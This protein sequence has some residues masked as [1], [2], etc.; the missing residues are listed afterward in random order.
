MSRF[1]SDDVITTD[2]VMPIENIF[3][4]K[5]DIHIMLEASKQQIDLC[6]VQ[7]FQL[8]I[9]YIQKHMIVLL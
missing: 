6:T 3:L 9:L 2:C 4:Q 8:E 7:S 1:S 5:R